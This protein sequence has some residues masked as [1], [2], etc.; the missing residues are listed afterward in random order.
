MNGTGEPD[1]TGE[2]DMM[3]VMMITDPAQR[4]QIA[5]EILEALQDWFEI[6]ETR[7]K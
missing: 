7:E 5:R 2:S 1:G 4:E 6:P 3:K